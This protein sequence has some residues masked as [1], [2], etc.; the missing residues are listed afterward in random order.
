MEM[1]KNIQ[2]L[3]LRS[4]LILDE[5]IS[6]RTCYIPKDIVGGDYYALRKLGDGQYGFMLADVMGHGVAA[7]LYTMHLSS[8][9]DRYSD[10]LTDTVRFTGMMNNELRKVIKGASF[11]LRLFADMLT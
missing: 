3:A 8:L 7:A 1:A 10:L 6:V 9:W 5:G 4:D 2:S 11:S